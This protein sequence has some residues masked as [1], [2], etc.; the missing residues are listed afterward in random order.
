MRQPSP[1]HGLTAGPSIFGPVDGRSEGQPSGWDRP[2]S[3]DLE[4]V[5]AELDRLEATL[6]DVSTALSRLERGDYESCESCGGPIGADRLGAD[7]LTRRCL[8]CAG[9]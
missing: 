8:Q 3:D 1:S 6:A 2:G 7:P 4:V 9:A 5:R